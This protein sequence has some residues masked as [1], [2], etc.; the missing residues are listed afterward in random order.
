VVKGQW[1]RGHFYPL[2]GKP[3]LSYP[4]ARVI[5]FARWVALL[6]LP[7]CLLPFHARGQI[8]PVKRELFQVGYDAAL[9]GH[10]P[11][12]VYA[13]FYRNQPD[14]LEQ[15]NLTLRLA[16]APTYL[17]SELGISGALGENTDIGIGLGGGGFADS[18]YEIR[19]I[20][21]APSRYIPKESFDGYSGEAILSVYHLFNPGKQVPLYGMVRGVAHYS[22]Y[23]ETSDTASDFTLPR[24]HGIFTVRTGLRW[25]GKE[26]TLF[27]A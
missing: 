6:A 3:I 20:G 15:S 4:I 7:A 17:D 9:E 24:D 13:F 16:I 26:P 25:C 23:E 22:F 18:Y 5:C 12:S 2:A 27:P 1:Y 19:Q 21:Q 11:L 10:P 8:D 14:F